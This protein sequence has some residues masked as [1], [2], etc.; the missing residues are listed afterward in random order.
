MPARVDTD[1]SGFSDWSAV[2]LLDNTEASAKDKREYVWVFRL[3]RG[4]LER[5]RFSPSTKPDYSESN[6][7]PMLRL[8]RAH[9]I[10]ERLRSWP[11]SNA[12]DTA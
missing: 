11:P 5:A 2:V 3:K 7:G 8:A 9:F 4:S 6:L 10:V 1:S 12:T